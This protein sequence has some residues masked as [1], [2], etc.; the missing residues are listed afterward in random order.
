MFSLV[1]RC[2]GLCGSQKY[3]LTSVAI[4]KSLWLAISGPRSQVKEDIKPTGSC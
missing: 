4:V 1:P 2:Q 3:T